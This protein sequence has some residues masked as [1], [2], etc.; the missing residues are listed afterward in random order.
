MLSEKI[1]TRNITVK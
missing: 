1:R